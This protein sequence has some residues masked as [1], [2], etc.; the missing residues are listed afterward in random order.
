MI[1]EIAEALMIVVSIGCVITIVK[2]LIT[3]K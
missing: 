1:K 3:D 2:N